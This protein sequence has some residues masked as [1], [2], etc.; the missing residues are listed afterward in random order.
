M[1][2]GTAAWSHRYVTV[3]KEGFRPAQYLIQDLRERRKKKER[4][5]ERR[6]EKK[7]DDSHGDEAEPQPQTR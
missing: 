5:K 4:K 6:K 7:R 1:Q 3:S 2:Q